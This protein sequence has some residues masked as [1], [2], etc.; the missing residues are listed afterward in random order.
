MASVYRYRDAVTGEYVT[1][2]YAAEHPDSTVAEEVPDDDLGDHYED[3]DPEA[4]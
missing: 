1:A 2:E 4:G 3:D